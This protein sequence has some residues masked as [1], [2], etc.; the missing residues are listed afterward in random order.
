MLYP[1]VCLQDR[2]YPVR[3]HPTVPLALLVPSMFRRDSLVS[4]LIKKI[5]TFITFITHYNK[6]ICVGEL[7]KNLKVRYE[8]LRTVR[9]ERNER[10]ERTE[11][12]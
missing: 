3:T 7:L 9:T 12:N 11:R 6:Q 2:A 1:G 4:L 8:R 10:V 5:S